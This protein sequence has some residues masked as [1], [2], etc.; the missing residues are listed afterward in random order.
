VK[1]LLKLVG[2]L[3][4]VPLAML[5]VGATVRVLWRWFMVPAFGFHELSLLHAYGLVVIAGYV[6][7]TGER[8]V[9]REH[10]DDWWYQPAKLLLVT[11]A[12]LGFGWLATK[13]LP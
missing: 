5:L 13:V 4:W 10:K 2:F 11:G 9:D 7:P 3:C 6:M 8:E 1:G 12:T